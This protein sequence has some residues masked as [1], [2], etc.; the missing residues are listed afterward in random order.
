MWNDV[1]QCLTPFAP[2]ITLPLC[3]FS[4]IVTRIVYK[5]NNQINKEIIKNINKKIHMNKSIILENGLYH[6]LSWFFE[7]LTTIITKTIANSKK[8]SLAK[9]YDVHLRMLSD[10]MKSIITPKST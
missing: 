3:D 10:T 9:F 5:R 6:E 7:Y 8:T 1:E 4:T 2:F